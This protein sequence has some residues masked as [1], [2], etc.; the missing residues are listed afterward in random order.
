MCSAPK[1]EG[2][3]AP[4]SLGVTGMTKVMMTMMMMGLTKV[5]MM[6]MMGLTK[7]MM[8]TMIMMMG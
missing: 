1:P 5:M 8:M 4:G 7:V 3:Q 2:S 6:M